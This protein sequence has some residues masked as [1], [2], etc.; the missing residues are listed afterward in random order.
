MASS[1]DDDRHSHAHSS[2]LTALHIS[3]ETV[4]KTAL[5]DVSLSKIFVQHRS[6][7]QSSSRFCVG[8]FVGLPYR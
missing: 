5:L 8:C 4:N 6:S 3:R 2:L 7:Q 1:L